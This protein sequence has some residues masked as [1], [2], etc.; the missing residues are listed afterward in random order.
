MLGD[1]SSD[2]RRISGLYSLILLVL[3][4]EEKDLKGKTEPRSRKEQDH[5]QSAFLSPFRS[6]SA[7]WKL[8][9]APA[10]PDAR[11]LPSPPESTKDGECASSATDLRRLS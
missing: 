10:L 1:I 6:P 5:S 3:T 4:K 11:R 9:K 8:P 7:C 2:G